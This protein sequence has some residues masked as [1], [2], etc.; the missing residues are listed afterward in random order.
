MH[1][2]ATDSTP[3]K[4]IICRVD[5]FSN[6]KQLTKKI[7]HP[8]SRNQLSE[9]V[10]RNSNYLMQIGSTTKLEFDFSGSLEA[11]LDKFPGSK[12]TKRLDA[13][14]YHIMVPSVNLFGA[15]LWLYSQGPLVKITFPPSLVT[16]MKN[17]LKA[18]LALYENE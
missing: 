8:Q 15:K 3:E 2:E 4:Q 11:A 6:I 7:S 9:D 1:M 5:R 14:T 18:M 10:L 13:K 16:E 12:V 17:D